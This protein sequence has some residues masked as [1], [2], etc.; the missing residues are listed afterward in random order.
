MR[1]GKTKLEAAREWVREFNAIQQG[2]IERLMWNDPDEWT[3]VT[4]PSAGDRVYVYEVPD[5]ADRWGSI[6]SYDPEADAYSVELDSGE[7]V[8]VAADDL[9]VERDGRL[10]MWGTMWSFGDSAD[11]YWL[12]ELDGIQ[13]MSECGFRVYA[14]EEFGFFFGIDGCGYDFYKA[15]WLPLYEKRGLQWHDPATEEVKA[16]D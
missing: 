14:H 13:A 6:S 2:L 7:Q 5:G 11:D 4:K 8:S 16:N 15:H 10:P 9:E 1:N 12:E 3:E